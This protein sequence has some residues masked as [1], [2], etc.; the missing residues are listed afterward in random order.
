[1]VNFL[2]FSALTRNS[3]RNFV[4]TYVEFVTSQYCYIPFKMLLMSY[5][6]IFLLKQ[7]P[8]KTFNTKNDNQILCL[9]RSI[10]VNKATFT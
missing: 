6:V 5:Y 4:V 8:N 10:F 9:E 1:M 7:K 3:E 2:T